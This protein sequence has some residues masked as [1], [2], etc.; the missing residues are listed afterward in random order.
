VLAGQK[1]FTRSANSE[2]ISAFGHALELLRSLP[3]SPARDHREIELRSGQ[4]LALIS[5]KGWAAAEVEGTYGPALELCRRYGDVPMRVLYGLWAVY[6]VRAD[7]DQTEE[8]VRR[9]RKHVGVA[10]DRVEVL[11]THSMLASHAFWSG[12]FDVAI[13]HS[14][15][16]STYVDRENPR[17]QALELF[18]QGYD[19]QLYPLIFKS[20]SDVLQ[21]RNRQAARVSQESVDIARDSKHPYLLALALSCGAAVAHDLGDVQLSEARGK[22]LLD[23]AREN[24]FA[25]FSGN[26]LAFIGWAVFKGGDLQRGLELLEQAATFHAAVGSDIVSAYYLAWLAEACLVAKRPERGFAALEHAKQIMKVKIAVF[27]EPEVYR[28][29][30]LLLS[31]TG[32][33]VEAERS[34]RIAHAMATERGAWLYAIR[35]SLALAK[36]WAGQG[37]QS[38]ALPLLRDSL[39]AVAADEPIQEREAAAALMRQLEPAGLAAGERGHSV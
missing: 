12:K 29:E 7:R 13:E 33:A 16:A 26:A 17:K 23:I 36:F 6:I 19:G 1:A 10:T 21:G 32:N 15:A 18:S 37:R 4:G 20:W 34:L 28:L 27:C 30:G 8:L 9:W 14:D 2:A 24:G 25:F 5:A 3:P 22:Q 31:S 35:A 39:R 11:M 38:E